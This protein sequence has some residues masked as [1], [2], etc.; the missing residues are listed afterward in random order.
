MNKAFDVAINGGIGR[1]Y[2]GRFCR[3]TLGRLIRVSV[4]MDLCVLIGVVCV[5]VVH[6]LLLLEFNLM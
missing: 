1:A 6:G 4:W 2:F 5:G 3:L